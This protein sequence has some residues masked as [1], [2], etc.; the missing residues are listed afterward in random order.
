MVSLDLVLE[1]DRLR[2]LVLQL[3]YLIVTGG[4]ERFNLDLQ[5]RFA[6]QSLILLDK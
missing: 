5:N 2:T 3:S 1:L 4:D 6:Q